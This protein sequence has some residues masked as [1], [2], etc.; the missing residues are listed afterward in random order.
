[1]NQQETWDESEV[2]ENEDLPRYG[3][4]Q[5][6]DG[7]YAGL[8]QYYKNQKIDWPCHLRSRLH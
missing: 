1:L 8:Q 7:I 2:E 4:V 6:R 3:N 5:Q